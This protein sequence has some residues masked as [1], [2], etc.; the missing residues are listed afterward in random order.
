MSTVYFSIECVRIRW[1]YVGKMLIKWEFYQQAGF[2]ALEGYITRRNSF[3]GKGTTGELNI[4]TGTTPP[5]DEVG[6]FVNSDIDDPIKYIVPYGSMNSIQDLPEFQTYN[7]LFPIYMPLTQ[8]VYKDGKCYIG[9]YAS[10]TSTN[11]YQH[12][13]ENDIYTLVGTPSFGISVSGARY[14]T[15]A[16]ISG[17]I[18]SYFKQANS[19]SYN[20]STFNVI[21][22]DIESNIS[23]TVLTTGVGYPQDVSRCTRFLSYAYMINGVCYFYSF[24]HRNYDDDTLFEYFYQ[25]QPGTYILSLMFNNSTDFSTLYLSNCYANTTTDGEWIYKISPR[26]CEKFNVQTQV[27][28]IFA[29]NNLT[30]SSAAYTSCP[31]CFLIGNNIFSYMQMSTMQYPWYV[32]LTGSSG[33]YWTTTY[34]TMSSQFYP[35]LQYSSLVDTGTKIIIYCC[36][37]QRC[38]HIDYSKTDFE[39]PSVIVENGTQMN[40]AEILSGDSGTS[41]INVRRVYA[42]ENGTPVQV[43]GKVRI[44]GVEWTDIQ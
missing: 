15:G 25:Y 19:S 32:S 44:T 33:Q 21:T 43:S 29:R 10:T 18:I 42:N 28:N 37:S 34:P 17:N 24:T 8:P 36:L 38:I 27:L 39:Y 20:S 14:T 31:L 3:S 41:T 2:K 4:W 16:T 30:S 26:R 11:I 7:S 40:Q 22:Y 9:A 13:I 1:K 5:E 35:V 12:D 23:S 6:V